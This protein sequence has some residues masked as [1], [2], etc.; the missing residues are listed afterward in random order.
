MWGE[1]GHVTATALL[2]YV[3]DVQL[4]SKA[5]TSL[6]GGTEEVTKTSWIWSMPPT[7]VY[8]QEI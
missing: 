7:A 1:A 8:V 3:T 4:I 5:D 2:L 6:S